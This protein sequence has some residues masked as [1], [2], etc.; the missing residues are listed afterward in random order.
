MFLTFLGFK[1]PTSEF[2]IKEGQGRNGYAVGDTDSDYNSNIG[3]LVKGIIRAVSR[4]YD[5]LLV[6]L[7]DGL[8]FSCSDL[9]IVPCVHCHYLAALFQ[10]VIKR[11]FL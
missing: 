7:T 1:I 2:I 6:K 4:K 5:V 3:V 9:Q 8:G 11:R 10:C